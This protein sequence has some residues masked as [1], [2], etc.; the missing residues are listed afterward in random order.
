MHSRRCLTDRYSGKQYRLNGCIRSHRPP[1]NANL[2]QNFSAQMRFGAAQLPD[3]VD[4]RSD[5]TRVE[6]QS[7]L[8]SW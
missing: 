6:D 5:M 4:F 1:H 8:G 2:Q 7:T 3:S